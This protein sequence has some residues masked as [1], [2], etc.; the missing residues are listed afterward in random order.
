VKKRLSL[1]QLVNYKPLYLMLNLSV[2]LMLKSRNN[3]S[4]K[5]NMERKVK[6]TTNNFKLST[7]PLER[8][9]KILILDTK[10][11]KLKEMKSN[12][13]LKLEKSNTCWLSRTC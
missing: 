4:R 5:K 6:S 2:L 13:K 8:F 11:S 10:L 12:Q 3:L 1:K 9:L 7:Q